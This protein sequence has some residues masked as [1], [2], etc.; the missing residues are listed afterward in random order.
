MSSVARLHFLLEHQVTVLFCTPT[1][2]LRLAEK[3]G[4]SREIP[5][6]ADLQKILLA[7][8][9]AAGIDDGPGGVLLLQELGRDW[10]A[11]GLKVERAANPAAA[12]FR[13]VDVE[14]QHQ[15]RLLTAP[16]EAIYDRPEW[17]PDGDSLYCLSD[18][19]REMAA[20]AKRLQP[21]DD[22]FLEWIE[23]RDQRRT[24]RRQYDQQHDGGKQQQHFN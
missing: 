19:G 12:D 4:T 15:P 6:R 2:A 8:I 23:R 14:G 21:A 9:Q 10:G 24:D 16:G 5:V 3:G 18:L 11:L 17:S 7:Y 13:L 1:Y 20:P 22:A